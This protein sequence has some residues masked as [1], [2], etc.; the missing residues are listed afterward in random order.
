VAGFGLGRRSEDAPRRLRACLVLL[1]LF[2]T[3]VGLL[4]LTGPILAPATG[5]RWYGAIAFFAGLFGVAAAPLLSRA[6]LWAPLWL[7]PA[8]IFG[9]LL[10]QDQLVRA[11]A[12]VK[13]LL[14][15]TRKLVLE[16]ARIRAA[17]EPPPPLGPA[18][19]TC[20]P[21]SWRSLP[22]LQW[23]FA[24]A[25][26]PPFAPEPLPCEVIPVHTYMYLGRGC[27]YPFHPPVEAQLHVQGIAPVA[28]GLA[29]PFD[30]FDTRMATADVGEIVAS[31]GNRPQRWASFG[32]RGL[33]I[34]DPGDAGDPDQEVV[35]RGRG[36][37][38]PVRLA[39]DGVDAIEA[40]AYLPT[41]DYRRRIPVDGGELTVDLG[42]ELEDYIAFRGTPIRF[43]LHFTG[44]R[45]EDP[46]RPF[47]SPLV[48]LRWE[49]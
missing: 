28:L 16:E 20:L 32:S 12:S 35:L 6:F 25:L 44:L 30:A 27:A 34:L 38:F 13:S 5:Q 7:V 1:A 10:L 2:A 29:N 19:V 43:Y 8:W 21:P 11:D 40:F 39:T 36:L 48:K 42:P 18:F 26:R 22:T 14:A 37:R 47:L 46:S 49:P 24:E 41:I 23:G 3:Q 45:D 9:H 4:V 17:M 33:V 15:Q 31:L